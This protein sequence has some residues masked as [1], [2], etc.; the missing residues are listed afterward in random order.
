AIISSVGHVI[1]NNRAPELVST[2]ARYASA[3]VL[4][5]SATVWK[6]IFLPTLERHVPFTFFY[7]AVVLASWVAGAGPGLL[8]TALSAICWIGGG[9]GSGSPAVLLFAL[10]ATALCLL[11]AV[12]RER[13][14]ETEAHMGRVFEDSPLG[15]VI[16]EGG[17]QILKANP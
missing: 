16:I 15:I 6:V 1:R 10:E 17:P 8:A 12:F 5:A 3:V 7:S 11:T 14:I 13:L 4:V 9:N 2:P